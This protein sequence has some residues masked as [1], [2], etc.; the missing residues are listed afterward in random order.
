MSK[1]NFLAMNVIVILVIFASRP[2]C[3]TNSQTDIA[4]PTANLATNI[5]MFL[6]EIY[7]ENPYK[8]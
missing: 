7:I 4:V 2:M 1:Q 8:T 3:Q 5:V 6:M